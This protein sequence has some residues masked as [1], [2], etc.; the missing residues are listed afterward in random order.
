ME[1]SSR[2]RC[3]LRRNYRGSDHF[4]AA[5][6]YEDYTNTKEDHE[7]VISSSSATILAV[8]AISMDAVNEY[9]EQVEIDNLDGRSYGI[10]QGGEN[11]SRLSVTPEQT[12]P[13]PVESG[14][15]RLANDHDLV[16]S[17]SAVPSGYVPS[18]LDER[19]VLELPS[20]M[21]R[22]LR[23]IRG[24]FQ[25]CLL[26]ISMISLFQTISMLFSYYK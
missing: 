15:I 3:C 25:V 8:E 13:V 26:S 6:N 24:T 2:M 7:N 21:V 4:G 10:E 5:A 1:S 19:I 23:V 18:E 17:S 16:E 12:L 22:P 20:S 9:D 11:Q 14:D